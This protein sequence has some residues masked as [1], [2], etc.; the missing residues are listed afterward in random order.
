MG[1]WDIKSYSA[2]L[3]DPRRAEQYAK[4]FAGG[5]HKRIDEREQ[6]A[7]RKIFAGLKE[8]RSVLDVPSGAPCV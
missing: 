5:A 1:K 2:R 6:R 4:R 7:V 8:C 3:Q